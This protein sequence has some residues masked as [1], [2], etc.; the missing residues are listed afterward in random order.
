M[1]ADNVVWR[2][3]SD[4]AGHDGP[5]PQ[6]G[7]TRASH[8]ALPGGAGSRRAR[9]RSASSRCRPQRANVL[10]YMEKYASQSAAARG[11]TNGQT[12]ALSL[13]DR[14][15][16][17]VRPLLTRAFG[18]HLQSQQMRHIRLGRRPGGNS[19][20]RVERVHPPPERDSFAKQPARED[21]GM[22][23]LERFVGQPA[24]VGAG[25]RKKVADRQTT[26]ATLAGDGQERPSPVAE[27]DE[28]G[29]RHQ[30]S[31]RVGAPVLRP[32][33]RQWK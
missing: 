26:A 6:L 28:H 27:R 23:L 2:A 21:L 18:T 3:Q 9:R 15:P 29:R 5:V 16:V 13:A 8:P 10:S 4:G 14:G 11:P 25:R 31:R 33:A 20:Q 12:H 30:R 32:G 7:P 24:A 17:T 22:R 19:S 1:P